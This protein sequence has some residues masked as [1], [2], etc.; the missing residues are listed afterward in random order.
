MA[1]FKRPLQKD[2]LVRIIPAL[3]YPYNSRDFKY[4]HEYLQTLECSAKNYF[5]K[6]QQLLFIRMHFQPSFNE[7]IATYEQRVNWVNTP[8]RK[9]IMHIKIEIQR[10]RHNLSYYN[11]QHYK[12]LHSIVNFCECSLCTYLFTNRP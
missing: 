4:L 5:S 2:Y 1:L 11:K 9:I 3:I 7:F 8:I 6:E 10:T 12:R